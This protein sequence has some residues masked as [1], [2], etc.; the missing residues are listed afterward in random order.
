MRHFNPPPLRPLYLG[1]FFVLM[2]GLIGCNA[3]QSTTQADVP[4]LAN[5]ATAVLMVATPPLD[6]A[7]LATSDPISNGQQ[8]Q[9]APQT[10]QG[11][12]TQQQRLVIKNGDLSMQVVSPQES[13]NR[14]TSWVEEH[15]GWVVGSNLVAYD[16]YQ[17][18]VMNVRVPAE[19]LNTAMAFI[20]REATKLLSES[21]TGAD[22]TAEFADA[23]SQ[24]TNLE[25]AELQLRS[26]LEKA[27]TIPDILAVYGQ[28]TTTRGQIEQ[29]KG[30]MQYWTQSAAFSS[31]KV[32]LQMEPPPTPTPTIT[33]T[34]EYRGWQLDRVAGDAGNALVV[35]LQFLI[36]VTVWIVIVILPIA[37]LV[38]VPAYVID[39]LRNRRQRTSKGENS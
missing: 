16:N 35:V 32:T 9:Q 33:P 14:I 29:I 36:S 1:V 19:E 39:R 18:A 4:A 28:L 27:T 22:V 2:I 17:K 37:L 21:I 38:G 15:S 8:G 7:M 12:Q 30:R 31:I 20:K 23:Q 3:A 6:A 26:I 13:I 10:Q 5:Q 34:P 11:Q 25:A 24:L